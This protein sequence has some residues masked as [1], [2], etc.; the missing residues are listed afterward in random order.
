MS[1]EYIGANILPLDRTQGIVELPVEVAGKAFVDEW[2]KKLADVAGQC[3]GK[4]L[5]QPLFINS[6][7][8][9]LG[10]IA[11][12]VLEVSVNDPIV[13]KLES[14]AGYIADRSDNRVRIPR[15]HFR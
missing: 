8:V 5:A 10:P 4:R 9:I 13:R 1:G 6:V 7:I 15:T 11:F 12:C 2:V 3:S 14:R